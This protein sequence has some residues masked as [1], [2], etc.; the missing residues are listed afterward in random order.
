MDV[1]RLAVQQLAQRAHPLTGALVA[2]RRLERLA[3]DVRRDD[4]DRQASAG[5]LVDRRQLTS[6]LREP[7]LAHAHGQQQVDVLGVR[8]DGR[9][10]RGGVDAQAV[11]GRQQ[12]V[13]EAVAVGGAHDVGA[14]FPGT[15]QR[16]IGDSEEFVVVVAQGAEPGDLRNVRFADR[17]HALSSVISRLRQDFC[18]PVTRIFVANDDGRVGWSITAGAHPR[19]PG[20]SGTRRGGRAGRRAQSTEPAIRWGFWDPMIATG[21]DGCAR[22]KASAMAR[23]IDVSRSASAS[24]TPSSSGV[25]P[26][27]VASAPPA[28]GLQASGTTPRLHAVV[29]RA[30]A[31]RFQSACRELGLGGH[32]REREV[33]RQCLDLGDRVVGDADL[34][35]LAGVAQFG[36]RLRPRRRDG[37]TGRDGGSGRGR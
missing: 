35:D 3:R 11:P 18:G 14:V 34:T 15:G 16:R 6:E 9:R 27:P 28:S 31:H 7:H 26:S 12:H 25:T 8:G 1:D 20:R 4:V 2:R 32:Q 24:S 19:T 37:C 22:T 36:E 29:E 13:V 30:V 23:A 17:T 33:R 10:E 5:E 21:A